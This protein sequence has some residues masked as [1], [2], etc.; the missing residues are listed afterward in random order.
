[1]KPLFYKALLLLLG[2]TLAFTLRQA[3]AQYCVNYLYYYGCIFGDDLD[4]VSVGSIN[5]TGT[6]CGPNGYSD[7]TNLIASFDQ[8]STYSLTVITGSYNDYVSMWIDFN[9]DYIF[10][11]SEKV[12][13]DLLCIVPYTNYSANFD[14]SPLAPPGDHRLRL[15]A[16]AYINGFDACSIYNYGEVHDYTAEIGPPVDMVYVSS[17]TT[18]AGSDSISMGSIDNAIIGMQVMTSGSLNPINATAF[19]LNN[20]G[21]TD[22]VDV[23][24]Y[25]IYYTGA[26]STFNS[27]NLFG[28]S[29]D[30]A[31][32]I[33][34]NQQLVQGVNYFWL[35]EDMSPTAT[36]GD[37]LDAECTQVTVDGSNY[38]PTIT[39]PSGNCQLG[40]CI[41]VCTF[42]CYSA[43]V[44]G[45]VLNTLS[46]V[47]SYCNGN[48][49]G[50]INYAPA[51]SLTTSL[52][53]GTSY[54][55]TLSNPFSPVGF[56]VWIDFNGDGD[57]NDAGEF[58]YASSVVDTGFQTGTVV[59]PANPAYVGERT[60]RVR[61]NG[62]TLI[63]SDQS[64]TPFNYG[65]TEDYT[66]TFSPLQCSANFTLY[67]DSLIPHHYWAVNLA[68]GIP[69]L[70]YFWSWGDSTYD[71][72]AY[73]SH[74]YAAAGFYNI[75]LTIQDSAG[76]QSSFSNIYDIQKQEEENTII[77]VDVVD[78]IPGIP[79]TVQ[80]TEV[81]QSLSVFPNPASGNAFVSYSLSTP[82]TV[83]I[84]VYDVLGNKLN[85]LSNN[86]QEQGQH[87]STIDIRNLAHGIYFLQIWAD[88]QTALQKMMVM[89]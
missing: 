51:G 26:D 3:Q 73:P 4:N 36:L 71:T 15:R 70:T 10:D 29:A 32:P 85:Q 24:S 28:S 56:G 63:T 14:I 89:N 81:L 11:D 79:T 72:I 41:P 38:T 61:C 17:T 66:I 8:G 47:N 62:Y 69:P 6:G 2:T 23:T 12:V 50:Y 42:S 40:Y 49:T 86:E 43:Y 9:D 55:I 64:C 7:Y 83:S 20:N 80:N 59:I 33:N 37:Y 30:L 34:G 78:S 25:K 75:G 46:N 53:I 39:A 76:C 82:A 60:M 27:S 77:T 35:A 13:T 16:V 44:D 1:M 5:Q 45:V 65:E 22:P 19:T 58:V 52:E 88:H 67:P 84:E 87:T 74:T 48:Y 21:S 18:Q 57:Y 68:I 31:T 54:P